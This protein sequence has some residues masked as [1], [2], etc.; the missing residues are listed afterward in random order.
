MAPPP[1][2]PPAGTE[3]GFSPLW[4]MGTGRAFDVKVEAAIL[5]VLLVV[6]G[7]FSIYAHLYLDDDLK[8]LPQPRPLSSLFGESRGA[9]KKRP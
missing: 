2:E 1:A 3:D 8:H 6:G 5:V 9:A 7:A 4:G